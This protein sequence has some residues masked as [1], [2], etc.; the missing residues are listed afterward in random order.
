MTTKIIPDIEV[1]IALRRAFPPWLTQRRTLLLAAAAVVGTGLFLN[2]SWLTAI[3]IAPILL[4]L[5]PCL[6]MCAFGL[7]MRGG[8]TGA[9]K[10]HGNEPVR[11]GSADG[12][13]R[14]S[15]KH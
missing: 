6:A 9:C 10:T 11:P 12:T 2:W 15:E 14:R 13:T 8:K 3:G 1:Q 7:C 4:S 5:A